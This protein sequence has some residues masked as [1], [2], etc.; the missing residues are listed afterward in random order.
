M[1]TRTTR[2]LLG[3]GLAAVY[4]A[5]VIPLRPA[6]PLSVEYGAGHS[7]A[8]ACRFSTLKNTSL[9]PDNSEAMLNQAQAASLVTRL[10]SL[11][12]PAR[13]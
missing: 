7:E 13:P 3:V 5:A 12:S 2:K 9:M 1:T 4:P 11:P 10:R 8:F 6:L